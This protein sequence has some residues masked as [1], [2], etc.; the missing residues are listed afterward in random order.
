MAQMPPPEV[1]VMPATCGHLVR[2]HGGGCPW[3]GTAH[4]SPVHVPGP[5]Q[6]CLFS[7]PSHFP[8]V[9]IAFWRF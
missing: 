4:G 7:L 1:C 5:P 2:V 3:C 8:C 6:L 9:G